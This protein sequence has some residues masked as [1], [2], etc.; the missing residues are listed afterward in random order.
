[1]GVAYAQ[2]GDANA[3]LPWLQRAA[4]TGFPCTPWYER[5]PML[6]PIRSDAGFVTLISKLQKMTQEASQRHDR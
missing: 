2:L 3:A 1:M 4:D 6:A 5:D